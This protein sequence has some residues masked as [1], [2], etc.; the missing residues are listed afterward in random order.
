MWNLT[1]E[2]QKRC[3]LHR[4]GVFFV[5]Y[6][7]ILGINL[8]FPFDQVKASW[9]KANQNVIRKLLIKLLFQVPPRTK[10]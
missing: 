5:K 7:H 9:V 1:R 2:P 3:R 8:V 4:C 10:Y 6:E